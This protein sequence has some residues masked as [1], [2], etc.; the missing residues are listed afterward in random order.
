MLTKKLQIVT[1]IYKQFDPSFSLICYY[2]FISG[3]LQ[4]SICLLIFRFVANEYQ[5]R[6]IWLLSTI[7]NIR[8]A[9]RWAIPK[10]ILNYSRLPSWDTYRHSSQEVLFCCAPWYES[11]K[12]REEIPSS[13]FSKNVYATF[14]IV[15]CNILI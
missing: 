4:I 6:A 12:Q 1:R 5:Q 9:I 7:C 15:I 10:V 8:S 13:K 11:T 14:E 3:L 2:S